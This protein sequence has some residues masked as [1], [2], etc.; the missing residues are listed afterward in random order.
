M[1]FPVLG[2]IPRAGV[3]GARGV[4]YWGELPGV[5]ELD[6]Q[7]E[8]WVGDLAGRVVAERES[9]R[10]FQVSAVPRQQQ[11]PRVLCLDLRQTTAELIKPPCWPMA[12]RVSNCLSLN[13]WREYDRGLAFKW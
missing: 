9:S 10:A 8:L 3:G 12:T 13:R 7:G 2:I 6:F 1:G 5:L 11:P 4:W